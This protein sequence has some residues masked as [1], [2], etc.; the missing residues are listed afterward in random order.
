MNA[1]KLARFLQII[2]FRAALH[3]LARRPGCCWRTRTYPTA[4]SA[5]DHRFHPH[6][7]LLAKGSTMTATRVEQDSL[8]PVNVPADKLWGAQTQRSGTL[9]HRR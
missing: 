1:V 4:N 2:D 9:R 3:V 7:P 5:D 8:G 6:P